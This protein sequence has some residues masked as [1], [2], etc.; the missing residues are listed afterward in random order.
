MHGQD[1]LVLQAVDRDGDGCV[2]KTV[3]HGIADQVGEDL[4]D[5]RLIPKA[6]EIARLDQGED[7]VGMDR[8]AVADALGV[9]FGFGQMQAATELNPAFDDQL[10][11]GFSFD[12]L[13]W[14]VG[15]GV[16]ALAVVF[17]AGTRLQRDTE[18]LV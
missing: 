5:A 12:P 18:G 15:F 2:G 14:L 13:P 11:V 10:I 4:A 7:A 16:M 17:Q 1:D 3:L 6:F 8:N 9:D